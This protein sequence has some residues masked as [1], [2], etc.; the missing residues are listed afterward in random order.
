[1]GDGA[2]LGGADEEDDDVPAGVALLVEGEEDKGDATE[3][4]L[5]EAAVPGA[6]PAQLAPRLV[7]LSA[8]PR[9]QW[10]A[11]LHME[12]LRARGRPAAPPTKPE[13]APF[14]LPTQ[15][16][17]ATQPVF[18]AAPSV[19]PPRPASRVLRGG[20]AAL[21]G[22]DAEAR[23][24]LLRAIAAGAALMPPDYRD[25][26]AYVRTCGSSA[27]DAELQSL[28]LFSAGGE[29]LAAGDEAALSAVLA[30]LHAELAAGRDFEL[31]H[32]LLAAVLRVHG[33]SAAS[34]VVLHARLEALRTACAVAWTR[35]DAHLQEACCVLGF[36]SGLG[37]A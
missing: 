32:A 23:S 36:L 35:L 24:P 31:L 12:T 28:A 21:S 37:Q 22:G 10:S 34:N 1:M 29:V 3:A 8:L 26:R 7:T 6:P 17:L 2:P 16:G 13:A 30:F 9:A 5:A 20:A 11:L 33:E 27:L 14:F 15:P 4:P 19:P 25:A 18:D